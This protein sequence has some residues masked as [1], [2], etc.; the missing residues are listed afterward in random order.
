MTDVT[1][2]YLLDPGEGLL[3]TSDPWQ[4]ASRVTLFQEDTGLR[5]EQLYATPL[6]A[7]PLP[8]RAPGGTGWRGVPAGMLWHP[9]LWLPEHLAQPAQFPEGKDGV[10]VDEDPA[11][12]SVRVMLEVANAGLY[13]RHTG[14]WVDVLARAGIDLRSPAGEERVIAWTRGAPDAVLDSFTIADQLDHEQPAGWARQTSHAEAWAMREA[15]WSRT[16]NALLRFT[17]VN[18]DGQPPTALAK[19]VAETA[20]ACFADIAVDPETGEDYALAFRG[21]AFEADHMDPAE[22]FRVDYVLNSVK[23]LLIEVE[24]TY[25]SSRNR[26][27]ELLSE[28]DVSGE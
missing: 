14:E 9:L 11:E 28:P 24:E 6:L 8:V 18:P 1:H 22:E 4:W 15:Q 10:L 23:L 3:F 25:R 7:H 19:I 13:D 20:A 2:S 17:E 5:A 21:Y 26:V 16:A 12:W 27:F